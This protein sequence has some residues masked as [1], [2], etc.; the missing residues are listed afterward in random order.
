MNN[1]QLAL[2]TEKIALDKNFSFDAV[3]YEGKYTFKID[4]QTT[5]EEKPEDVLDLLNFLKKRYYDSPLVDTPFTI[6]DFSS[7]L[8]ISINQF[9]KI[10]TIKNK[11]PH[12]NWSNFIERLLYKMLSRNIVRKTN[13]NVPSH[14][15]KSIE[16]HEKLSLL[17]S[18][19]KLNDKSPELVKDKRQ[20]EYIA[21]L[22]PEIKD[23]I[24]TFL[25]YATLHDYRLIVTNYYRN[26]NFRFL[27]MRLSNVL[28]NLKA[29]INDPVQFDELATI[30]G[31]TQTEPKHLR[32]KI[33]QS[34]KKIL[35]LESLKGL[36]FKWNPNNNGFMYVPCF[37]LTP[38]VDA[39]I[40]NESR[41]DKY[42]RLDILLLNRL[43]PIIFNSAENGRL[44]YLGVKLALSTS[45]EFLPIFEDCY[46]AVMKKS[47]KPEQSQSFLAD[48]IYKD[49][50][51]NAYA[52]NIVKHLH[53]NNTWLYKDDHRYQHKRV[54]IL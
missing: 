37:Y 41:H 34:I 49:D 52:S 10:N 2:F 32:E 24:S 28:N 16:A 14:R 31:Y 27:Y 36:G 33:E 11:D 23:N 3:F 50:F 1:D 39:N 48:F 44:P 53:I 40:L 51:G 19:Y 17:H 38:Q 18:Y 43:K 15:N 21:V 5:F 8:G 45:P 25:Y 42:K 30:L 29:S 20:L 47:Y 12:G 7:F 54:T 4:L 35:T 9:R 46:R 13:Y 22:T 6:K 26:P